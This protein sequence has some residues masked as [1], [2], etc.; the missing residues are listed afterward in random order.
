MTRGQLVGSCGGVGARERATDDQELAGGG[1][2]RVNVGLAGCCDGVEARER[3]TSDQELGGGMT[4]GQLVDSCGG[5]E[6][7]EGANK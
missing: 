2:G 1:V 6:A 5:V 4:R 7:R 3:A